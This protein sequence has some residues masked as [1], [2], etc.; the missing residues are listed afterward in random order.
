M[1]TENENFLPDVDLDS[2]DFSSDFSGV[3]SDFDIAEA[4]TK[5]LNA[6]ESLLEGFLSGE[7]AASTGL[8]PRVDADVAALAKI[9]GGFAQGASIDEV[10][11]NISNEVPAVQASMIEHLK[12]AKEN[13]PLT[14]SQL[15]ASMILQIAPILIGAAVSGK[16]GGAVGGQAGLLGT[17]TFFKGLKEKEKE[18]RESSLLAAKA[19]ASRIKSLTQQGIALQKQKFAGET[20]KEVARI[21]AKGEIDA[22]GVALLESKMP[23]DIKGSI[24]QNTGVGKNGTAIAAKFKELPS[25]GIIDWATFRV[26]KQ[27]AATE[28]G[29]LY[30]AAQVF[31][32]QFLKATQGSRPSDFDVKKYEDFLSGDFTASADDVADL[33]DQA[34]ELMDRMNLAIA[35]TTLQL[36]SPE[37]T[38]EYIN[39]L[40]KKLSSGKFADSQDEI[41]VLVAAGGGPAG[42]VANN[43]GFQAGQKIDTGGNFVINLV[44]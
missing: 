2:A 32:Q 37:G 23:S 33:I 11:Q 20:S 44:D 6:S 17:Q 12:T 43:T 15:I 31:V 8:G 40:K 38:R 1:T 4:E 5:A 36:S 25:D 16:R 34:V 26:G 9:Q 35:E 42:G 13:K 19:D 10:L 30:R 14:S 27:F 28:T 41:N 18:D 22:A 29:K 39:N 24:L 3:P 21:R 7:G